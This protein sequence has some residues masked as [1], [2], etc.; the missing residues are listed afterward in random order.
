MSWKLVRHDENAI[1][2]PSGDQT[3]EMSSDLEMV[4]RC[5]RAPS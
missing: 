5:C 2:R 1:E 3:G 4:T